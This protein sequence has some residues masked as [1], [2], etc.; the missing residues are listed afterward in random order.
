M[1]TINGMIGPHTRSSITLA[2]GRWYPDN[3]MKPSEESRTG[4]IPDPHAGKPKEVG[5]RLPDQES[6]AQVPIIKHT[7]PSGTLRLRPDVVTIEVN[8]RQVDHYQYNKVTVG[9][10]S[11]EYNATNVELV[12]IKK[13]S[14]G[15]YAYAANPSY[16][17]FLGFGGYNIQTY[18]DLEKGTVSD[19]AEHFHV[20]FSAESYTSGRLGDALEEMSALREAVRKSISMDFSGETLDKKW[21]AIHDLFGLGIEKTANSFADM[22]SSFFDKTGGAHHRDMV[23]QSVR[24]L[25]VSFEAKYSSVME[26]NGGRKD[27]K[28][29][30]ANH[31]IRSLTAILREL[32]AS[33]K[34]EGKKDSEEKKDHFSLRE[35]EYAAISVSAY[36]RSINAIRENGCGSEVRQALNV[37]M[38]SMKMEVLSVRA[39]IGGEM[40]DA[41]RSIQDGARERMMDAMDEHFARRRE[42]PDGKADRRDKYQP[43]R[44]D[45][46]STVYNSVMNTFRM[47]GGAP[48]A[49]RAGASWAKPMLSEAMERGAPAERWE[50]EM[51]PRGYWDSFFNNSPY[52]A[53]GYQEYV[54]QWNDFLSEIGEDKEIR[55]K[56]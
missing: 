12:S 17:Q 20:S 18:I 44:R 21:G 4:G 15:S 27:V 13:E 25:A 31:D 48:E 30:L 41:V 28:E 39:G 38:F 23:Y 1:A 29:A 43:I 10:Q 26:K 56:A 2:S 36:Q 3:D 8:S 54:K 33:Y 50:N 52:Q 32:G 14:S 35:L 53:G 45:I 42:D 19:V 40:K 37:S 16:G 34:P 55:A 6:P 51:K 9:D 49:I 47:S 24:A 46:F 5:G 7:P 22:I 11:F